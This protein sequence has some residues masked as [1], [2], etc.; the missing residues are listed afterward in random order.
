MAVAAAPFYNTAAYNPNAD[1]A[2]L[3]P[4]SSLGGINI[5]FDQSGS[6]LSTPESRE[7]PD[8]T[9]TDGIDNTFFGTDL[10]DSFFEGVDSDPH[11]NFFGT[12][13]AAPN[14][15]AIGALIRQSRPGFSPADVYDRLEST[16]LDVTTRQNRDGGF[17]TIASGFDAW[18]GHGFVP[19]MEAVPDPRGVRI[20][21]FQANS[22]TAS[23][24]DETVHLSWRQVGQ[25]EVDEFIVEQKYFDGEFTEQDRVPA[26]GGRDYERSISG[27]PVGKHTFRI[28]AVRNGQ[29]LTS[30][31]TTG[32]IRSGQANVLAYP[33]PFREVVNLSVTLRSDEEAE[34]VQVTVFDALGRKVAVPVEGRRVEGSQSISLSTER[35]GTLGEGMYFLRVQG[36]SFVETVQVVR[37]E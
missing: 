12:S 7:K 18:S 19:G 4:F 21:Q 5:L 31:I 22:S 26:D 2:A 30:E 8:V 34:D 28:T 33:N 29:T 36:E 37:V 35:L 11:P 3:E 9:G 25:G 1:P 27:L 17:T 23:A 15:A 32:T 13:A 16:A 20:A 6:R 14:V 24:R 10:P